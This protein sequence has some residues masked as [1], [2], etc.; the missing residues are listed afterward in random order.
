MSP[1]KD[2]IKF[3]DQWKKGNFKKI[4]LKCRYFN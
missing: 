1:V 4:N 3:K 2:Y